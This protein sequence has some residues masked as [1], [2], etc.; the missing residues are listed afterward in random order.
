MNQLESLV[1]EY[2][3]R[4]FAEKLSDSETDLTQVIERV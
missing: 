1:L 3:N 2:V 4:V